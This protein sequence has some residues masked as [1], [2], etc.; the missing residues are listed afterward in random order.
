MLDHD[1]RK[2]GKKK[3]KSKLFLENKCNHFFGLWISHE[4]FQFSEV[5]L[6]D[7]DGILYEMQNMVVSFMIFVASIQN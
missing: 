5:L 1:V 6:N 7:E 4:F 3:K 2:F